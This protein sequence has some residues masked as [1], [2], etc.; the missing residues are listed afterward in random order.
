LTNEKEHRK[1]QDEPDFASRWLRLKQEAKDLP[2]EADTE[3]KPE[4]PVEDYRPDE[5]VLAELDLPDPDTLKPGDNFAAFMARTVP[6]RI[7]N[8]ALRK[9]WISDPVLANLDELIDYGDDFTDAAMVIEN[10]QTGYQVGKGWVDKATESLKGDD[11]RAEELAGELPDGEEAKGEEAPEKVAN[12]PE[13]D[14]AEETVEAGEEIFEDR[15]CVGVL[16]GGNNKEYDFSED[17]SEKLA[18][19]VKETV[20]KI[21]GCFYIF[22]IFLEFFRT[23]LA[24][25]KVFIS[26]L[27]Q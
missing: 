27:A 26:C 10:L 3:S 12:E 19:G 2:E 25:L 11:G 14:P 6:A 17:V 8:R 16:F 21:N 22:V 23:V 15:P 18:R 4:A 24:S 13:S 5:E 20:E 1:K 9:L 7:R